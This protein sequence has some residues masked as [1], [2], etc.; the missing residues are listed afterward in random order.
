MSDARTILETAHK[1]TDAVG[2][3]IAAEVVPWLAPDASPF[4]PMAVASIKA[5]LSLAQQFNQVDA[6]QAALDAELALARKATDDAL[7]SKHRSTP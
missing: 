3:A 2:Q 6:V 1:I 5:I 7:A 4:V